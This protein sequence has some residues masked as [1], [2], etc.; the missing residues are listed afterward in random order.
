MLA[1]GQP[2]TPVDEPM[3]NEVSRD[4]ERNTEAGIEDLGHEIKYS[5]M[6]ESLY[7]TESIGC[8]L[9]HVFLFHML[10]KRMRTDFSV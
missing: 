7:V 3:R 1:T 8:V 4:R 2:S 5:G 10:E 6:V 9:V